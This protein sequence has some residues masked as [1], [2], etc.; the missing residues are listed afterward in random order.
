MAT[1]THALQPEVPSTGSALL[2]LGVLAEGHII[3]GV[4]PTSGR[5]VLPVEAAMLGGHDICVEELIAAYKRVGDT[6]PPNAVEWLANRRE[7]EAVVAAKSTGSADSA[8][9]GT[10][11]T[12]GKGSDGDTDGGASGIT[13]IEGT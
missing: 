12:T 11:E 5:S 2:R 7:E 4:D 9:A 13:D 6:A 10:S 3:K 1:T 8:P